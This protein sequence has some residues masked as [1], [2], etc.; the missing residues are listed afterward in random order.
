[1]YT[2]NNDDG[3][4]KLLSDIPKLEKSQ[5]TTEPETSTLQSQLMHSF[6]K[7]MGMMHTLSYCLS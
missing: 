3:Y 4:T 2:T 6:R 7:V 1:M 5:T